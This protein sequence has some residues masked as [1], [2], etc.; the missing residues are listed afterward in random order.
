MVALAVGISTLVIFSA[1]S[2]PSVTRSTTPIA[3][4]GP[5]TV[6]AMHLP[7]LGEYRT[8][9]IAAHRAALDAHARAPIDPEWSRETE[10]TLRDHLSSLAARSSF[11][12]ESVDCKTRTCVALLAFASYAD[13]QARWQ[14][15]LM[16]PNGAGCG[17]EVTLEDPADPAR[18][19]ELTFVYQCPG[20]GVETAP[21]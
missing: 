14:S 13:A 8:M 1:H 12:V 16:H 18:R 5:Q 4:S 7:D 9:Q 21:R 19:Y 6:P 15:V 11:T 20:R 3:G 10:K 17:S 2:Q